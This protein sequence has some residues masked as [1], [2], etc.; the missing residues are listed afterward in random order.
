MLAYK[1]CCNLAGKLRILWIGKQ[2]TQWSILS[3]CSWRSLDQTLTPSVS[4]P[5][6]RSF[7]TRIPIQSAKQ[8]K[9]AKVASSDGIDTH[10]KRDDV[11]LISWSQYKPI[12]PRILSFYSERQ[13]PFNTLLISLTLAD[14]LEFLTNGSVCWQIN[15][16][17]VCSVET[18]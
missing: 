14:I 10:C 4:Q 15:K 1:Q 12:I 2:L 11:R 6:C 8:R 18:C 13:Q 3:F 17:M 16:H 7:Q 9:S 5:K